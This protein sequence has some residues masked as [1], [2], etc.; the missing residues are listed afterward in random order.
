MDD[1]AIVDLYWMR[2]DQAISETDKKY[3]KY[4]HTIAYNI[5]GAEE[6][7]EECVSDTWF[8]A[9]N[10]MP[11]KRPAVLSVF[12]GGITRNYAIDLIRAR[13]RKKRGEGEAALAL[14]ELAESIPDQTNVERTIEDRELEAAIGRFVAGLTEAEKN[15]F[16]LRYWYLAPVADISQRLKFSQSKTKSMLFRTRKKLRIFLQEE[17]LC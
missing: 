1:A 13:N 15:V 7:A 16:V 8:R 14:E 10:L 2:S 6:D 4:C 5:C 3:G 17:G 12:L 9:W 11:D